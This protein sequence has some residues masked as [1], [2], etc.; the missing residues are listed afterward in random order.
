MVLNTKHGF[1]KQQ[2]FSKASLELNRKPCIQYQAG[3][4]INPA[5]YYG[6]AVT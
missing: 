1:H 4:S 2:W 3:Y 5:G 6:E